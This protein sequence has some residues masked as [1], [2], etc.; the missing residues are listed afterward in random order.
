MTDQSAPALKKTKVV[1]A[2]LMIAAI[3]VCAMAAVFGMQSG[4]AD[5]APAENGQLMSVAVQALSRQ[6]SYNSEAL[7]PGRVRAARRSQLGFER[8]GMLASVAADEGQQIAK[9]GL[10]A[11]LDQRA[12]KAELAAAQAALADA[13]A[14]AQLA[15]ATAKRQTTLQKKGNS[16]RQRLDESTF[17]AKAARARVAA[18]QAQ[19]TSVEVAITL[20]R[21]VAPFD[22]IV[23]NRMADEG[24]VLAPGTPIFDFE[25]SGTREFVTGV[26]ADVVSTLAAGDQL[27]VLLGAKRFT[28]ALRDKVAALSTATRTAQLILTLPEG[29]TAVSGQVGQLALSRQNNTPGFWVPLEALQEGQRGL[30]SVLV[31]ADAQ[32]SSGVSLLERHPVELLHAELGRGFV[33]G[34]IEDGDKLVTSGLNRLIP[35]QRVRIAPSGNGR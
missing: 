2:V 6:S 31:A 14:N 7:Y 32:A 5:D 4:N 34:S 18:A 26:P 21:L 15:D 25:E 11:Q 3:T 10:L 19:L 24:S 27:T 35:N 30:W 22:G 33:R 9:G 12:L 13:K 16:S 1:R 29:A 20:S 8:G 17:G 23:V 28:A